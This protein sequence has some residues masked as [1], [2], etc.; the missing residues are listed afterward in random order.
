MSY[1]LI[2]T[3]PDV[4]GWEKFAKD[5]KTVWDGVENALA[6]KHMRTMKKGDLCLFYHTGEERRVMG[7][8]E[9]TS[10]AYQDPKQTDAKL[11]VVDVKVKSA[12]KVPVGLPVIK[13]DIVFVGW[14]LTRIGRLSVVPTSEAMFKRI[15][16]LG[17]GA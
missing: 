9:V 3:E 2:K 7:V 17:K 11:V 4:Y 1:W 12:L 10:A 14:D 16:E 15:V 8:A 5:K 6:L 13:N